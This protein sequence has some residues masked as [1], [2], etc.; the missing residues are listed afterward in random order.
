MNDNAIEIRGL[1][2]TYFPFRLG[3]LDL[4]VPR[5]AIVARAA[6]RPLREESCAGVRRPLRPAVS[7][8][9]RACSGIP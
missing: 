9:S 3:A 7:A 5:G 6:R 8:S 2:K 4:T 1:V